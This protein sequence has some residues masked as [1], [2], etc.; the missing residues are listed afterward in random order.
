MGDRQRVLRK[1]L[2]YRLPVGSL[3]ESAALL[4]MQEHWRGFTWETGPWVVKWLSD[5][6]PQ[7]QVWAS[8]VLEGQRVVGHALAHMGARVRD[9]EW[10]F[11]Y[12]SDP[13]YG[14]ITQVRATIVSARQGPHGVAPKRWIFYPNG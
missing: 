4:S 12:V 6:F 1:K 10:Q 9:G 14:R 3:G 2:S 8:S 13:R 7:V 11:T 5:D